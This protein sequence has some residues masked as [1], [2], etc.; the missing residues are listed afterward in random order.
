MLF[1]QRKLMN[2]KLSA[3]SL[4]P[5]FPFGI[6]A[7]FIRVVSSDNGPTVSSRIAGP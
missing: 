7:S 3:W 4:N 6:A 2:G 5:E 1:L